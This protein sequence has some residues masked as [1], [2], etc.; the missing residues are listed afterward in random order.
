T[1]DGRLVASARW[2][3]LGAQVHG[4]D[5]ARAKREG[6]PAPRRQALW[7]GY[8]IR[9]LAF[10]PDGRT[11]AAARYDGTGQAP[12]SDVRLWDAAAGRSLPQAFLTGCGITALAFSPDGRTL[13]LGT[14]ETYRPV[15]AGPPV[16]QVELWDVATGERKAV[17]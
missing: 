16:G 9:C 13:G 12:S 8:G 3:T 2:N 5:S 17:L 15:R 4:W 14:G 7:L 11:L 10:A 6:R 1:P